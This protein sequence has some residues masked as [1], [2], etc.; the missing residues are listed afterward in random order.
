MEQIV[1]SAVSPTLRTISSGSDS[2]VSTTELSGVKLLSASEVEAVP[3]LP[4][5]DK[6]ERTIA[7]TKTSEKSF[8]I[9]GILS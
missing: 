1:P 6:T 5:A 3:L 8:F 7:H 4:H 2:I 9:L